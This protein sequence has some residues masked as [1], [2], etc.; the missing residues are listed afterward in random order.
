V[1]AETAAVAI[2]AVLGKTPPRVAEM[3]DMKAA[4]A[5]RRNTP[6]T[7]PAVA[8]AI[9]PAIEPA[10]APATSPLMICDRLIGLALDADRAGYSATAGRLVLL[11][12][13]IFDEKR[14]RG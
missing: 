12:N 1:V 4:A 8:P 3:P 11:A 7:A 14:T 6:A 2:H 5:V 9:A 10:A 13:R